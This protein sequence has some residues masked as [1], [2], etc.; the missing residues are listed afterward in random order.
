M[1]PEIQDYLKPEI[2]VPALAV[3]AIA[4]VGI[5]RFLRN[6][7]RKPPTEYESRDWNDMTIQDAHILNK[8]GSIFNVDGDKKKV[9]TRFRKKK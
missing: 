5:A 4:V 9:T 3:S 6:R 1:N 2:I 8:V 7:F